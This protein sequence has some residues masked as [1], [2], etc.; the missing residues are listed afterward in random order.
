MLLCLTLDPQCESQKFKKMLK[1]YLSEAF[2]IR[3]CKNYFAIGKNDFKLSQLINLLALGAEVVAKVQE[4]NWLQL[5]S[6]RQRVL[7]GPEFGSWLKRRRHLSLHL[8]P[9]GN[10]PFFFRALQRRNL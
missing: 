10:L 5:P 4:P 1:F 3:I 6:G 8:V 9:M 7:I 2:S